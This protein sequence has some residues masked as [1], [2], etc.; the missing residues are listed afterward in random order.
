MPGEVHIGEI[1]R[2][3]LAQRKLTGTWLAEKMSLDR[4]TIYKI[5]RKKSIDSDLLLRISLAVGYDFFEIYDNCYN[6]QV[7]SSNHN[8]D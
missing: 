6:N 8:Q 3:Q 1:I 5:F 2:R 7:Q 4:T